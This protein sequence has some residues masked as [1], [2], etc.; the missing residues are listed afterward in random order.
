M[1]F[2]SQSDAPWPGPHHL[3]WSGSGAPPLRPGEW[4]WL[5][6]WN[7]E[8]ERY[9]P[10]WQ[11]CDGLWLLRPLHWGLPRRWRFHAEA[12]QRRRG[13]G[14]LPAADL[15]RLVRASLCSLPPALYQDPLSD[16]LV[17][18]TETLGWLRADADIEGA[19]RQ[20]PFTLAGPRDLV[21][22]DQSCATSTERPRAHAPIP[23]F[24]SGADPAMEGTREDLVMG[25]DA[26]RA[27]NRGAGLAE[28]SPIPQGQRTQIQ[29]LELERS[30][31]RYQDD[32]PIQGVAWLDGQRRCRSV[33]LQASLS[34][35][36]SATG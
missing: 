16:A 35:S 3:L 21:S 28:S 34:P 20:A 15:E 33:W 22:L 10:L 19:G 7:R 14:W 23:G 32:P 26:H 29:G 2:R 13:G 30:R 36:S 27:R 18:G 25:M 17:A 8:L 11:A 6:R 12:R 9:V 24:G 5:P 4:Q 1:L 31:L